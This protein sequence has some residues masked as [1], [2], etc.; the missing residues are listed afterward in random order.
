MGLKHEFI[1]ATDSNWE[2]RLAAKLRSLKAEG[3]VSGAIASEFQRRRLE[4][5][6]EQLSIPSYAPLWHKGSELLDEMLANM[7]I[8]ITAVSAEGLGK[9]WLGKPLADLLRS[10][11]KN[12]NPF[13]EGGEGETFVVD[14]LFF[15]K[16]IAIS[17][18]NIEWDGVRGVANIKDAKLEDKT[19]KN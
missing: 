14:A 10:K 12:I 7:E 4:K 1:E 8:Y 17:S 5:V 9:E 13:L 19:K 2:E 11:P 15:K 6:C 16:R 18:W 3:L